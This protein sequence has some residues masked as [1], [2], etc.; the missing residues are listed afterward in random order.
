MAAVVLVVATVVLIALVHGLL[1]S[2]SEQSR[3]QSLALEQRITLAHTPALLEP[4]ND[5]LQ[6]NLAIAES[7]QLLMEGTQRSTDKAYELL[8][9][10]STTVRGDSLY[11]RTYQD[12]VAAKWI[13]DARKAHQ[14]H[15]KEKKGGQLDEKD[16][17]K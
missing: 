7:R 16:V 17:F 1:W 5:H 4:W 6:L 13:F 8:L 10:Y 14:Q 2:V 3:D 12:T 11:R 9:P 15:A